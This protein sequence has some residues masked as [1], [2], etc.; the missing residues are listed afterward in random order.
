[1]VD[2][3]EFGTELLTGASLPLELPRLNHSKRSDLHQ[4][5]HE[6]VGPFIEALTSP[7]LDCQSSSRFSESSLA[8][9]SCLLHVL[10]HES[11]PHPLAFMAHFDG[12]ACDGCLDEL[13]NRAFRIHI[14]T[15]VGRIT[16]VSR[17]NYGQERSH[18]HDMNPNKYIGV[19]VIW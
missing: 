12:N 19:L 4:G 15:P 14:F 3:G 10:R 8:A 18:T 2:S 9:M 16:N 7:R 17:A 13:S 11:V 5:F 1:M 6:P